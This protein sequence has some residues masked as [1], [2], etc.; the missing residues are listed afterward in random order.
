MN[1]GR[2]SR[3]S[4]LSDV[5][6]L[7]VIGG[8]LGF[9]LIVLILVYLCASSRAPSRPLGKFSVDWTMAPAKNSSNEENPQIEPKGPP[10]V[11]IHLDVSEPMGGF[12]P[13]PSSEVTPG[14]RPFV[15]TVAEHLVRV[16]GGTS[17]PLE[18]H[19]VASE[20][21]LMAE[22]PRLLNRDVLFTGTETRLDKSI[23][24][25]L[26]RLE[27]GE[28]VAAA[29]ITDLNAT[30][31]LTGAMG[32][33]K[34]LSDWMGSPRVRA[35]EFHLGLLAV[36]AQ[37]W[38]RTS[39]NCRGSGEIGCWYSEQA[40]R[41]KPM[42]KLA[43]VPVYVLILAKGQETVQEV[44]NSLHQAAPGLNL[45]D[46][47]WILLTDA[48]GSRKANTPC[49]AYKLG[50]PAEEQFALAR[51]EDNH[52][53]CQRREKVEVA[54]Y[55]PWKGEVA[56]TQIHASWNAVKAKIA[57]ENAI[58]EVDCGALKDAPAQESLT[59]E[60][61]GRLTGKV[62]DAWWEDWT[63]ATDEFEDNLHQTLGLKNFVDKVLLNPG[64]MKIVSDPLLLGSSEL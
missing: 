62:E 21:I 19:Q 14:F 17:R 42:N 43:K 54:C 50:S 36:R 4:I 16:A 26:K 33:A 47:Q 40:R 41:Y 22:P 59:I 51:D 1:R 60:L 39:R 13:P 63:K 35:G 5:T 37:Y 44:G 52:Y 23:A 38:G 11:V 2:Q 3:R 30:E 58:L 64:Q 20:P 15:F 53:Q 12:L 34:A 55:L 46:P 8:V 56:P 29:L 57:G 10:A 31:E 24:Q 28:V 6:F 7:W 49:H 27:N 61:T 9:G 32:A 45:E 18:W 25:I 48:S